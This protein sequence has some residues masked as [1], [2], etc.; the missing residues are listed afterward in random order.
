MIEEVKESEESKIEVNSDKD[1]S[2]RDRHSLVLSQEESLNIF[3]EDSNEQ[4]ERIR[5]DSPFKHLR[6]WKLI[7]LIVKSGA[8]MK[9]E[10]FAIQLISQFDQIFKSEK[11]KLILTPY[12][13]V[14][15][16]KFSLF[17]ESQ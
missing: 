14:S 15:L 11:I 1:S 3:G 2:D 7:H 17:N 12:E 10:Q 9:E 13:I 6:S 4:A 5:R 8:D 16:G